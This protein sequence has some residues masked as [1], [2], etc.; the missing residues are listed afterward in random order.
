MSRSRS[1]ASVQGNLQTSI[2]GT[3]SCSGSRAG[4]RATLVSSKSS[5]RTHVPDMTD[6]PGNTLDNSLA[7]PSKTE[8]LN[9]ATVVLTSTSQ[10][11]SASAGSLR[12]QNHHS[13]R[14]SMGSGLL[15]TK[16]KAAIH[17]NPIRTR[18][19]AIIC[20]VWFERLILLTIL[21]NCVFLAM[22]NPP[23]EA[24]YVFTAIFSL[25]L[26]LKVIALSFPIYIRDHWNKLDFAVVLLAYVS[27]IPGVS[28]YS[29]VRALR[30]LRALRAI[31][32][33]PGLK[34]I[35]NSVLASLRPL[36]DV[37]ILVTFFLVWTAIV[38]VQLFQGSLRQKCVV[39]GT[40]P[41]GTTS[42]GGYGV[43]TVDGVYALQEEGEFKLCG[44]FLFTIQCPDS[45]DGFAL[46]CEAIGENPSYGFLGF[47]NFL[48]GSL[49]SFQLITLDFWESIY[50]AVNATAG[51]IYVPF[52]IISVFVGAFF[53]INLM[54]AVVALA[55]E[56]QVEEDRMQKGRDLRAAEAE[57][58]AEGDSKSLAEIAAS[59]DTLKSVSNRNR[60]LDVPMPRLTAEDFG[61]N[62]IISR[63]RDCCNRIIINEVFQAV[64]VFCILANTIVLALE[65]PTMSDSFKR[66]TE[67]LNY[68]FIAI[69]AL[70]AL[71]KI[72]GLDW[73]NWWADKFNLFD[74][75][76]V[77]ISFVELGI[78]GAGNLSALRMLRTLRI[79]KMA[80]NWNTMRKLISIMAASIG[81]LGN[82]T[83]VLAIIIYVFAVVGMQL[84]N[85]Y[86]PEDFGGS[87][88]AWNFSD[89]YASFLMV[90]RIMCGEWI[91]PLW[92]T[93][94]AYNQAAVLFYI[95]ALFIANFLLLN[96]FLALLLSAFGDMTHREEQ[97]K[98]NF[99]ASRLSA[100][101]AKIK[102]SMRLSLR[103]TRNTSETDGSRSAT[104]S[105]L[106]A[107]PEASEPPSECRMTDGG[108]TLRS[109]T[110]TLEP[111]QKFTPKKTIHRMSL[112]DPGLRVSPNTVVHVVSR[113]EKKPV[114]EFVKMVVEHRYF[115]WFIMSII[116]LSSLA[117]VFEDSKL[118][119]RPVLED[120]LNVADVIFLCIFSLEAAMKIYAFG[121]SNY[122]GNGW[123]RLD[124]VIVVF[125]IIGE[126]A[127]NSNLVALR[128]VR[129]LR[130]LRPLRAISRWEGM[131]VVVDALLKA[132]PAI[133]NVLL[134]CAVLWLIFSIM[135]V[136]L[137]GAQFK[138]CI[139]ADG[140]LFPTS[141]VNVLSE[142]EGAGG[143][144][145]NSKVNFDNTFN[146]FIALFQVATFEGWMEIMSDATSA[147]GI[148]YQP[149]ENSN[150]A[151]YVY[152]V[153]FII[154]GSF[155][156]LNLFIGV[157]I[158]EFAKIKEE[159]DGNALV[160]KEQKEWFGMMKHHLDN[161][162][163]QG[164][165]PN[166][167]P[168]Q[169]WRVGF[170]NLAESVHFEFFVMGAICISMVVMAL[171]HYEQS[172][173][174]TLV[175]NI[176]NAVFAATFIVESLIK[177]TGLGWKQYWRSGWNRFDFFVTY[178]SP[179][180]SILGFAI[181]GFGLNLNILRVVRILRALRI[182][183][184]VRS[185]QGIRR[186]M[187]TLL[188]SLPALMNIGTLL[189]LVIFIYSC[190]G[191]SLFGNVIQNGAIN[192]QVNFSTFGY[193]ILLLF[194]LST[195]AGWND[196]MDA[197][198]VSE[199][200]CDPNYNNLPN[201]N[202]GYYW[203]SLLYFVSFIFF[204]FLVVVNM[205]VAVILENFTIAKEE[206]EVNAS[207]DEEDL[208]AFHSRW[209]E[210]D[211]EADLHIH[212]NE[213]KPF[214]E[215][216]QGRLALPAVSDSVIAN[217][218][219]PIYG[220]Q[221]LKWDV[222]N[223]LLAEA[224][225]IPEIPIEAQAKL[226]TIV[227]KQYP[228]VKR[229]NAPHT[230]VEL[231]AAIL[232]Q[233]WVR[234][235][236]K[237]KK[238]RN[239][240]CSPSGVS[241]AS[242]PS[243]LSPV[244]SREPKDLDPLSVTISTDLVLSMD[245]I[246]EGIQEPSPVAV[247]SLPPTESM[248]GLGNT[249]LASSQ[250]LEAVQAPI[251][252]E[253]A[254]SLADVHDPS[255]SPQSTSSKHS[256]RLPAG[257]HFHDDDGLASQRSA[258]APVGLSENDSSSD[259]GHQR[260]SGGPETDGSNVPVPGPPPS[261]SSPRQVHVSEMSHNEEQTANQ[262]DTGWKHSAL[263]LDPET[264]GRSE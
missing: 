81:A 176:F 115:E 223:I 117:L 157:I 116:A 230:T 33:L 36:L 135:G 57:A 50:D 143:T 257:I 191:M 60:N 93:M 118:P 170:F 150:R 201:G 112:V 103:K 52:F 56:S 174:F 45:V 184:L 234:K 64:I 128:A 145:E 149:E 147:R 98:Q 79:F 100:M 233:R 167:P 139:D 13:S 142:C 84:F 226:R 125:G 63:L 25:E 159:C 263:S 251:L 132:F 179:I 30:V 242:M 236:L 215:G 188:Y 221:I 7:V 67:G 41:D 168:K 35:V 127:Q 119:D 5:T 32:V 155:F 211:P 152:F 200:N 240:S 248:E 104:S 154:V 219:F 107:V 204:A 114:R 182:L 3:R 83:L 4:S 74:L 259:N 124:F 231:H 203:F 160:S 72:G 29:A 227:L 89:F 217:L 70:E 249:D 101:L 185:A 96:L 108:A 21:V 175:L 58:R 78:A 82:L 247:S 171:E 19:Y 180:G 88:P 90:F 97:V 199:P 31:T 86:K 68:F 47:D 62:L 76:I 151:A 38:G 178:V 37:L 20:N 42:L 196:I 51:W 198:M 239:E 228:V 11:R 87:V 252:Q 46:R 235:R 220:D 222:L 254:L 94:H 212:V 207:F 110:S 22:L 140:D 156:T 146:G 195:G 189:T 216:L 173:T 17:N 54:L 232:I 153:V 28:N 6:V 205:Y 181:S 106:Q 163:E 85:D 193:A 262:D 39:Q 59:R 256:I 27:F 183:R 177:I 71:L 102:P 130:A 253:S 99:L 202:C 245:G 43:A 214:L 244:A 61:G 260:C 210:F 243:T 250:N 190:L 206:D 123:N 26:V 44:S 40:V 10:F 134:V 258:S 15:D 162:R 121:P 66:V 261:L 161:R 55:Y 23:A 129:A 92:D 164:R 194:R 213:L 2:A 264:S 133:G 141:Q 77:T 137:F 246:D 73:K 209:D 111:S 91:E 113:K 237:T 186:L 238:C 148:G 49:A 122:F 192:E 80:R 1:A 120:V 24:E 95:P 131:K 187:M 158:D 16:T 144:I 9:M 172:D 34:I 169:A 53:V 165:L 218:A 136:G 69:F 65:Y 12:P 197:T 208:Q 14:T 166:K 109:T 255:T 241:F 138:K 8:P 18:C 225:S 126:I 48:M 224:L 75:I 105:A 229:L